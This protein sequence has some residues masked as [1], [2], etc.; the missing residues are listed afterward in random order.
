V[1]HLL[2]PLFLVAAGAPV[3]A[4]GDTVRCRGVNATVSA[5]DRSDGPRACRAIEAAGSLLRECGL[6]TA[7]QYTITLVPEITHQSTACLGR[8]TCET[9]SIEVVAPDHLEAAI[10]PGNIL[11]ALDAGT[12]FEGLVVHEWA[13]AMLDEV[14]GDRELSVADHEYVAYAM[15]LSAMPAEQR[16]IWLDAH[17]TAAPS[18]PRG[19]NGLVALMD[20]VAFGARSWRY[21]DVRGRC[22]TVRRIIDGHLTFRTRA[23]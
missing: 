19:I 10:E 20:P 17:P 22:E 13:H 5:E 7:H 4:L 9:R 23:M 21:F 1:R 3:A 11:G 8:Y 18:D 6:E 14:T 2:F 15:Q 16:A 12:L